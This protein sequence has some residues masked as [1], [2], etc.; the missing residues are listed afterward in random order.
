MIPLIY[1]TIFYLDMYRRFLIFLLYLYQC[2]GD[3][4]F[5]AGLS[6]L[7]AMAAWS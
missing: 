5:S 1:Y 7:E 6:A 3:F 2:L 4:C